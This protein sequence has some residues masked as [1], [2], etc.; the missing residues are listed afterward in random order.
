MRFWF[1]GTGFNPSCQRPIMRM[2][3]AL[4]LRST[5]SRILPPGLS[6]HSAPIMEGH[7]RS[8]EWRPQGLHAETGLSQPPGKWAGWEREWHREHCGGQMSGL[9]PKCRCRDDFAVLEI[10]FASKCWVSECQS[11]CALLHFS[12]VTGE[13]RFISQKRRHHCPLALDKMRSARL[14][15]S[16][17]ARPQD[18]RLAQPW[19]RTRCWA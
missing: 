19:C 9:M 18:S 15:Y 7:I 2:I 17:P 16:L 8:N 10:G 5:K 11:K 14:H 13:A 1:F 6:E 3:Q 4:H 12:W